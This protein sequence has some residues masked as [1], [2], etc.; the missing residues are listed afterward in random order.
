M[1][2]RKSKTRAKGSPPRRRRSDR[3]PR[4]VEIPLHDA[5]ATCLDFR[6]VGSRQVFAA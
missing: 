5:N 6:A 3:R 4:A 1:T 2:H